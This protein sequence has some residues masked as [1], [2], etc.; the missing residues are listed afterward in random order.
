MCITLALSLNSTRNMIYVHS[1][2]R[3]RNRGSLFGVY[4]RPNLLT[5]THLMGFC[6]KAA[7]HA[8]LDHFRIQW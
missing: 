4:N 2:V 3:K 5:Q 7:A 1:A 8:Q 6:P